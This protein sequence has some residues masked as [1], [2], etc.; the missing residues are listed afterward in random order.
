MTGVIPKKI[1]VITF[2]RQRLTSGDNTYFVIGVLLSP[3][4]PPG[5][6][7]LDRRPARTLVT[8]T[9]IVVVVIDIGP[10]QFEGFLWNILKGD[11]ILF[12]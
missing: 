3:A 8:P 7:G 5:V 1:I 4:P 2:H 12:I 11:H 9:P 10:A 6:V